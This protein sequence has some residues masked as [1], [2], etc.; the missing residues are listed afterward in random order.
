MEFLKNINSRYYFLFL[1]S[2]LSLIIAHFYIHSFLVPVSDTGSYVGA[3]EYLKGESVDLSNY[4]R[5]LTTPLFLYSSIFFSYLTGSLYGGM[6]VVNLIFYFSI[7]IVF[8]LLVLEIY[9]NH[10]VA[11]LSSVLFISNYCLYNFGVVY[12]AD[13]G[14]WF[15]FLLASYFSLRYYHSKNNVFF[16]AAILSSS[17]GVLFKEYGALGLISLSMLIIISDFDV[18]SKI[19]KIFTAGLLFSVIPL[20]YQLFFYLKFG[21]SYLDWYLYNINHYTLE[22]VTKATRYSFT[23]LAK[24]LGWLYSLG[25]F[26][27]IFGLFQEKKYFNK[28]RVKIL[29]ALLPASLMFL[30]WPALTQRIAFILIPWL[31]LV[32][33]FGLSKIKNKYILYFVLVAYILFNYNITS[34]LI[35]VINL[36]F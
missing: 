31:A 23:L 29:L 16:L 14:G 25:W 19:K 9:R 3:M 2:V 33:G 30:F 20:G 24:V 10:K 22:G 11:T 13:I 5:V 28:E 6:A 4:N 34:Y 27:F 36:P 7:I 8:Y 26:I 32:S 15:F 1:I 12:L 17:V 18:K 21:Y 35:K